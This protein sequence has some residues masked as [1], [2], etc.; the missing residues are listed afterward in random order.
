ML[1]WLL[2]K[3]IGSKNERE[4]KKLKPFVEKIN[5]LEG[6]LDK[7][8]NLELRERALNL[9]EKIRSSEEIK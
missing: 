8:T 4:I 2:N 3:I 7:L 9:F 1:K 6:E 5:S